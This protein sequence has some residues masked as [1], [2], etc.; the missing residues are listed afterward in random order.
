MKPVY[1]NHEGAK[2]DHTSCGK[3]SQCY[4]TLQVVNFS[5][6]LLPC[7]LVIML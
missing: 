1:R 6:G 5:T 4:T 2:S 7:F 3:I